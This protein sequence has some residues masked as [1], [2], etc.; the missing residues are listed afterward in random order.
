M[1]T[2]IVPDVTEDTVIV[3]PDIEAVN[4]GVAGG[5]A[6]ADKEV[7]ATV[8]G[9]LTVYVPTLPLPVPTAVTTVPAATPGPT[10]GEPTERVPDVTELTVRVV[11]E[12]APVKEATALDATTLAVAT[13]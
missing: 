3:L 9:T 11:P 4:T 5:G 2:A 13:V 6:A 1:P 10:T 12:M 8:W 7:A